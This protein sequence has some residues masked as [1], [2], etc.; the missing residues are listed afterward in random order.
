MTRNT[1]SIESQSFEEQNR[2]ITEKYGSDLPPPHPELEV[3]T[4]IPCLAELENDNFW[5]LL[6]SIS[7][8]KNTSVEQFEVLYGVNNSEEDA[9]DNTTRFQENQRTLAIV[10]T[11]RTLQER[12]LRL[13]ELKTEVEQL[14]PTLTTYEK[15]VLALAVMR[16]VNFHGV[17]IS[18]KTK[19]IGAETV[20]KIGYARNIL[21]Q[22]AYSRLVGKREEG[23]IDVLDADCFLPSDYYKQVIA[24]KAKQGGW[25]TKMLDLVT[26]DIPETIEQ[27][28]DTKK[29]FFRMLFYLKE[30]DFW[31]LRYAYRSNRGK[32][33]PSV[34]LRSS[35]IPI[36]EGYPIPESSHMN[37]DYSFQNLLVTKL[38]EPTSS[39]AKYYNSF[40][41]R[42]I[43]VDGQN[44]ASSVNINHYL[45]KIGDGYDFGEFERS[46]QGQRAKYVR[47]LGGG[48]ID[49]WEEPGFRETLERFYKQ[50]RLRKLQT[51]E[52][53]RR[54]IKLES[55][56]SSS[57]PTDREKDYLAQNKILLRLVKYVRTDLVNDPKFLAS[58]SYMTTGNQQEDTFNILQIL[59]PGRL[60]TPMEN[61]IEQYRNMQGVNDMPLSL[62][63]TMH[64]MYP[65]ELT[66]I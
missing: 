15:K 22:V 52:T 7:T 40:R 48:F 3:I 49:H 58:I 13:K 8:Q 29:A 21:L 61:P 60:K 53:T 18:S 28:K 65:K 26:P 42:D 19:S 50:E 36:I 23:L 66:E 14:E 37:S 32:M 16:G 11:I 6:R 51:Q 10:K 4:T 47:S 2:G 54:L 24:N 34:V 62:A 5:R 55:E 39:T 45:D 43:S 27:D 59:L 35:A 38:G 31:N 64:T 57:K 63:Y 1:E 20:N 25:Y 9:V 56:D 12:K 46:T 44:I 30:A 41:E 17:D 33:G